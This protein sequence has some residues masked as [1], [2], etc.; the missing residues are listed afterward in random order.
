MSPHYEIR[1]W[2]QN[3]RWNWMIVDRIREAVVNHGY[4]DQFLVAAEN[5]YQVLSQKHFYKM[6]EIC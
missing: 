3:K 2:R 5:A 4:H 6:K 1:I